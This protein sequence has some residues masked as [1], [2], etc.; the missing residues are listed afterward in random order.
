MVRRQKITSKKAFK[1]RLFGS[2]E[3]NQ[4]DDLI[5]IDAWPRRASLT[6]FKFL[7]G[8]R[9]VLFSQDQLIDALFPDVDPDKAARNLR[10]RISEV[11][12]FLEPELKRGTDSAFI[13][14]PAQ[15]TYCF[16]DEVDLWV[17]VEVF[18]QHLKE[19]QMLMEAQQWV[20]AAQGFEQ[21][22]QLYRG[23]YLVEDRYE[24]WVLEPQRLLRERWLEALA[25]LA[26]CQA[27]LG[28]FGAAVQYC[29]QALEEDPKHEGFYAQLMRYHAY[30]GE[31]SKARTV[32]QV[33]QKALEESG[34]SPSADTKTL[35]EQIETGT[36]PDPGRT[37]PHNLPTS[38]TRFVGRTNDLAA[39]KDRL[40]ESRLV[41]LTGLGGVGKTRL[42]LKIAHEL[43][44]TFDDG[45]WWI[46]LASLE[47]PDLVVQTVAKVL[48]VRDAPGQPLLETLSDQLKSKRLLL[49]LDNCEHVLDSSAQ[50]AKTLLE[51]CPQLQVLATS[52]DALH[53]A[54]EAH[55][56]V[57]PLSLPELLD[58]AP[59]IDVLK[60][61]E[62][63]TLFVERAQAVKPNFQLSVEN[64]HSVV[65]LCH[66]L[67]GIP[68]ALELAAARVKVLSAQK[69]VE[70]LGDSFSVLS[71]GRKTVPRQQTLRAAIDWSY[72]PLEDQEKTLL[73]RLSVFRGGF[74]LEAAEAVCADG[75]L[76]AEDVLDWLG[77]LVEK[78]LVEVAPDGERYRLLQI[79]K[80]FSR[81]QLEAAGEIESLNAAHFAYFVKLGAE[82]QLALI[83][84]E[85]KKWLQTL[86]A[87][88]N[89]MRAALA[90]GLDQSKAEDVLRLSAG[91]GRFWGFS[92]RMGEGRKW[93]AQALE[94]RRDMPLLLQGNALHWQGSLAGQ[95]G[96]YDAAEASLSESLELYQACDN[97]KGACAVLNMLANVAYLRNDLEGARSMYQQSVDISRELGDIHS[98]GAVLNNLGNVARA[99][100]DYEAAREYY[101]EC[102]SIC[103]QKRSEDR[104]TSRALGNL[105]VLAR[106]AKDYEKSQAS[107]EESLTIFESI[108][109]KQGQADALNNLGVLA[110][111]RERFP[112][113]Q[114]YFEQSC[115]FCHTTGDQ[116][117]LT[118]NVAG[119]THVVCWQKHHL[120]A[121]QLQGAVAAQFSRMGVRVDDGKISV[122]DGITPT[123]QA[124]LGQDNYQRA[125]DEG[126]KLSIAEALELALQ[127]IASSK[128]SSKA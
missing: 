92:G 58:E 54:G 105:G 21:A 122:Y 114:T 56:A 121:A 11:R 18:R 1:I 125:F 44:E 71:G 97:P 108:G 85:Q 31:T 5:P 4:G 61:F 82:S 8:Q 100:K 63:V 126:Q 37:I 103:R 96:D 12:K 2:F 3:L 40:A 42:A 36:L 39:I 32:Y 46:D 15:G 93:L 22:V 72:N 107:L 43:V 35:M 24:E 111:E 90:W 33:C 102:V 34:L 120:Q 26:T 99:Q 94:L 116:Y 101:E 55:W 66:Q 78:S 64:A 16:S 30:S 65:Y 62:A 119:L 67:D 88:H 27:Q 117:T 91:L 127:G 124:E 50:L 95:Q 86:E 52:R 79:V 89:N 38:L 48:G 76:A 80:Q 115:E 75:I 68:L 87:E 70:R 13:L 25:Q 20:K 84:P 51:A 60:Q 19:A 57:G 28:Q 17:D 49:V 45:A 109:D 47:D 41:T 98:M 104:I 73:N 7:V 59:D 106:Y 69:L 29:E 123:L 14:R 83:G 110:V 77:Q 9:G 81:E 23:P 112:Q 6:L 118:H 128:T 10:A 113:A 53:L 74:S